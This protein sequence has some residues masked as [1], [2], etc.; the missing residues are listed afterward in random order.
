M[1]N[2]ERNN[3]NFLQF[4]FGLLGMVLIVVTLWRKFQQVKAYIKQK[5]DIDITADLQ[6]LDK[7]KIKTEVEKHVKELVS[8]AVQKADQRIEPIVREVRQ[9]AQEMQNAPR[10]TTN[11][12]QLSDRQEQ[13]YQFIKQSGE[14]NMPAISA[15]V[16]GV[17]N[18]TLRRDMTKLEKL[19]LVRQVGKT[20]GSVYKPRD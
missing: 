4:L 7:E 14:A 13:I 2:T 6:E 11:A 17:T 9:Q 20:R 5:W 18:R 1:R 16:T 8:T 19:G 10:P 12:F 3:P 15:L